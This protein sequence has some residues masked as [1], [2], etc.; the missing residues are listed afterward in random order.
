MD[1][2][3]VLFKNLLY[4]VMS[5]S[6]TYVQL[7]FINIYKSVLPYTKVQYINFPDSLYNI[8]TVPFCIFFQQTQ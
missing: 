3:K 1:V 5:T 6:G 8:I 2:S 4:L 7:S